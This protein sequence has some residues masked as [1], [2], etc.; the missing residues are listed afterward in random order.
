MIGRTPFRIERTVCRFY[1]ATP[2]TVPI[3]AIPA[4][5]RVRAIADAIVQVFE[6]EG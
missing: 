6:E 1:G 2:Q 5:A 4:R 3:A